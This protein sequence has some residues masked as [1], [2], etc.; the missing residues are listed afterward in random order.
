MTSPVPF[1]LP[2]FNSVLSVNLSYLASTFLTLPLLS[3]GFSPPT[4]YEIHVY[5]KYIL[6]NCINK[7][8]SNH[9]VISLFLKKNFKTSKQ[10]QKVK[11]VNMNH[12][13][14]LISEAERIKA[15]KGIR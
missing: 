9:T 11:D 13:V 1:V 12:I 5:P 6:L 10:A 7:S 15:Q 4:I 2:A 8:T 14:Y 3:F